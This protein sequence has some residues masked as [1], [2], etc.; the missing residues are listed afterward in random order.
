M[1]PN[2]D[3]NRRDAMRGDRDGTRETEREARRRTLVR[4]GER[5][6]GAGRAYKTRFVGRDD[7]GG[8]RDDAIGDVTEGGTCGWG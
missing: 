7:D 2:P 3:P 4:C 6:K 5:S 8:A 1:R